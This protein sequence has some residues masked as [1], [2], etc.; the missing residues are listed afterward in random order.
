[1][2]GYNNYLNIILPKKKDWYQ[3]KVIYENFVIA[4]NT[5]AFNELF[6][7]NYQKLDKIVKLQ[8]KL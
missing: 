7:S 1:M 5:K 4:D 8:P 2:P 6:N 3:T